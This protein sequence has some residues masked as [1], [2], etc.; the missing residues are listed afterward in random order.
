VAKKPST[1]LSLG[2][3][4]RRV[5]VEDDVDD[6]A[7]RDV[8]LDRIEK[9]NELLMAMALHA[10]ADDPAFQDVGAANKVVVPWRL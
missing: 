4:V 3:L 6:L 9:A 1:A 7:G 8:G 10:A 5:V 2:V